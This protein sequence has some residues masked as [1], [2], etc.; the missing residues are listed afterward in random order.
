[1]GLPSAWLWEVSASP[2]QG[3]L[4]D[5]SG[6]PGPCWVV[7]VLGGRV[8]VGRGRGVCSGATWPPSTLRSACPWGLLGS[9]PAGLT[10][11]GFHPALTPRSP[12][13]QVQPT[14]LCMAC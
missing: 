9:E 8:P 3:P 1:M 13:G 6:W 12:P 7:W 10:G 11:H 14:L 2:M 4:G 5:T